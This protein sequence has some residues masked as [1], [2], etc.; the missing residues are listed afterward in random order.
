[1]R[2]LV[3]GLLAAGLIA[4]APAQAEEIGGAPG[5]FDFYVLSLSW[6]P[7]YCRDKG[8]E[9]DA[10]QCRS[11]RPYGFIVH[12]LWPQ[13]EQ[14]YPSNCIANPPRI[15]D[16]LIRGMLDITPSFRLVIHE[17]RKHGTCSG[18]E[19]TAY[20]D[21]V[22]RAFAKVSIPAEFRESTRPRQMAAVEVENAFV[23]EN[24][25]L[26]RDMIA[27]DCRG[28]TLR[29]VR[30]CLS[31]DLTF[32]PCAEVDRRACRSGRIEVPP[33]REQ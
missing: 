9:R 2:Q 22:R 11:G 6:S 23:R 12:G 14:G 32:R 5:A 7:S 21:T 31:R 3:A 33:V 1:V 10:E 27:V 28:N 20:F 30:V 25:G 4:A 17:W 13:F 24:P 26:E 19:P 29:E 16:R 18:L 15:D 8:G